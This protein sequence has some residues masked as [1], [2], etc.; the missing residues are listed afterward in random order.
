MK[1]IYRDTKLVIPMYNVHPY[2]SIKNL[3][4]KVC[5][6]HSKTPYQKYRA[7]HNECEDDNS[8]NVTNCLISITEFKDCVLFILYALYL[9]Q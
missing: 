5:I 2:F 4:T 3:G 7:L 9:T 8:A 1:Y 6:I